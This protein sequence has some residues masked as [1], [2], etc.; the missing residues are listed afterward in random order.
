M[1]LARRE[2]TSTNS[3]EP[4]RK[5]R[6][7][8]KKNIIEFFPSDSEQ[9]RDVVRARQ[10]QN[11]VRTPSR[12]ADVMRDNKRLRNRN[13]GPQDVEEVDDM[14]DAQ[15]LTDSDLHTE[16]APTIVERTFRDSCSNGNDNLNGNEHM[17]RFSPST[18]LSCVICW[19]DFS[20]TRGIL[21]C[22]HRFCF[23]C[24]QS[25]ADLMVCSLFFLVLQFFYVCSFSLLICV[26]IGIYAVE[27]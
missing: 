19:T 17:A 5:G 13:E 8:M 4:R 10:Q 14:N 15:T 3:T 1:L 7:L 22:G 25:W 11:D 9:V 27:K 12:P 21:P 2:R 16:D 18:D 24:I 6:R 23:S 26:L 20:S